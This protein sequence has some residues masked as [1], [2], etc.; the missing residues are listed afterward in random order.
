VQHVE[1]VDEASDVAEVGA[2]A[3][4]D[5]HAAVDR[6]PDDQHVAGSPARRLEARVVAVLARRRRRPVQRQRRRQGH[7]T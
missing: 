6:A 5:P 3:A 4:A 1:H 2:D 7:C